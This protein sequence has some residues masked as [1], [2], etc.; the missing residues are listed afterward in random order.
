MFANL[1]PVFGSSLAIL[2]LG[3]AFAAYHAAA[4][5]LVIMGI[6]IAEYRRSGGK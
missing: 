6:L 1:V 5:L 3:E 2:I 4:L